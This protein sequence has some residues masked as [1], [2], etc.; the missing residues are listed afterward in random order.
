MTENWTG[1]G[2]E[3]KPPVG[4]PESFRGTKRYVEKKNPL[5]TPPAKALNPTSGPPLMPFG[6]HKGKSVWR[7]PLDYLRWVINNVDL[8]KHS[9]ALHAAIYARAGHPAPKE[10]SKEVRVGK[11]IGQK[12]D[13]GESPSTH[14]RFTDPL[15]KTH[16][17]PRGIDMSNRDNE[18]VPF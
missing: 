17:I 3:E 14:Y 5:S 13:S 9:S 16:W 7:V 8:A 12:A 15:G 2:Y 1:L 6:K 4:C 18:P 11:R 10:P